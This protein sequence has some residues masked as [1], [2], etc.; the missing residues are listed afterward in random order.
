M[1]SIK[2]IY[3]SYLFLY[4]NLLLK[5][6][7]TGGDILAVADWSQKLSFYQLNGKQAF[8]DRKLGFDATQINWQTQGE[9]LIITGSNRQ[10]SIYT[11][12]GVKL[13]SLSEK[14]SWTF[15]AK[16]KPNSNFIVVILFII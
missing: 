13:N 15:C 8:K 4:F 16:H 12:E 5:K 3:H 1:E 11:N 2:V 14:S 7:R 10:C 6:F 9:F